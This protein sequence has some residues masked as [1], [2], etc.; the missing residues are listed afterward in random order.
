MRALIALAAAAAATATPGAALL[1]TFK[2]APV[3]L[4]LAALAHEPILAVPVV[5]DEVAV[6][7]YA[8]E[9]G[10][11]SRWDDESRVVLY[12]RATPD[13]ERL[14]FVSKAG[15][16]VPGRIAALAVRDVDGDGLA[17]LVAIGRAHGPVGKAT[18]M[19]F[20][21]DRPG[22]TFELIFRRR[23]AASALLFGPAGRL[24]YT[25]EGPMPTRERRFETFALDGGMYQA[26]AG[27]AQPVDLD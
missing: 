5:G 15:Q 25:Y 7:V 23:Q 3:G 6:V 14:Q 20:R 11:L 27:D 17:E 2:A 1:A 13:W 16:S 21:R 24:T 9:Q 12:R 18:L 22:G 19:V 26:T 4:R 8:P 10:S